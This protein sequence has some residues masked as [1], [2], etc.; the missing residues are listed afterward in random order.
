[1]DRFRTTAEERAFK[2]QQLIA[3]RT[4][5]VENDILIG[6]AATLRAVAEKANDLNCD[7]DEAEALVR[8]AVVGRTVLVGVRIAA[9]VQFAIFQ[10]VKPLAEA[11]MADAER[12]RAESRDDNRIAQAVAARMH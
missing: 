2:L 1:M 6:R 10:Y 11:D 8:A 12:S 7:E 4:E 9:E 3:A 5:A